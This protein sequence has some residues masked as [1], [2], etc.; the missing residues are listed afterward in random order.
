MKI[1]L[2]PPNPST[3]TLTCSPLAAR[4]NIMDANGRG[5]DSR[6]IEESRYQYE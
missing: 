1:H 6:L 2:S 5:K 4:S 3:L